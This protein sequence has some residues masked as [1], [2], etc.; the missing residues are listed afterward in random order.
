MSLQQN[1]EAAAS[2]ED[3]NLNEVIKPYLA[4]WWWFVLSVLAF[5]IL[6]IL[7]I[8]STSPSYK[9][10]ST[11]LV[12]DTKKAPS[13]D[14]GM[15][16]QL[17]GFGSMGTNS[18]DNEIEVLKSKKLMRDVV[19]ELGL[20]TKLYSKEGLKTRELY[21]KSSPVII[22]LINEKQY[23]EPIEEPLS[24]KI[25]GDKLELSS[26]EL[27]KTI[28]TTYNKTISLPYANIMIRKNVNYAPKPK[29]ELGDL[30]IHYSPT[31]ATISSFQENI[32][33]DLV[34]KDAT[35]VELSLP[36]EHIEKGKN[37]IN[38]LVDNYNSDAIQDKNSESK[39]TK[40]FIDE[41]IGIIA[42]ELGEV[43]SQKEQFKVANNIT[44]IP[45]EASLALG[46]SASIQRRL[47]E[48][49][50]QLQLTDD[51]IS[52]ASKLGSN[53]TFPSSVGLSNPTASA[54][55]NAYNQLV[56]ER[57][58]LLENA[59]PQNPVVADLNKQIAVL[60]SSVIDAL[61]KNKVAMQTSINQIEGEQNLINSKINKIPAQEKLFRSIERQQQIKENLYLMLLQ[62]R[63]EAAISLAITAPKA[64]V[65]DVAYPSDKPVSPKKMIIAAVALLLGLLF[66]FAYIYLH[67][68]FNDKIRSKHDIEKNT[69]AP[70]IGELPSLEKGDN[71]IVVQ[72]DLSPMAEAFRILITNMN[73]MLPKKAEGKVIFVSSS[74]KGEG[75][76]FTSV[77]L[78][79]TLASV[80]N[81]T[82]IIGSDIRNPQLQRY[83]PERKGLDG[84]TEFLYKEDER[85]E[86]I[87]H[88]STF[89]PHLDLIYSGSIPPNP[90]ELLANGRYEVLIS[91]LK[92]KYDYIIVDTAPLMLVTDTLLT[93]EFA[94][95]TLYVARSGITEKSL[96][97]FANTQI[98]SNKIKNVGFVLNDVSKEHFGYGNKYG[99]GYSAEK[100][101]FWQKLRDKF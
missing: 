45:A 69:K 58:N 81:K 96:I 2:S 8:K 1:S 29:D 73:F 88:V 101:S 97:D 56:L 64:R 74:V 13:S 79:L 99:Y 35:V 36:Y 66:P 10:T 37:I 23:D 60:R 43:E 30:E 47:L 53:Q 98:N 42:N 26:P 34:N 5:L 87:I 50:T 25:S 20:Q 59:T 62:R 67:E 39:K 84:L 86:D 6:A 22:Q 61:V 68:L 93:T 77:N 78:A 75:K 27:S 4:K 100:R 7:Y 15:L 54:N 32:T 76:T 65:I 28:I 85:I 12:K 82:I 70:V 38:K 9:I 3:I 14:M 33:I 11:V 48:T 83:N 55:I 90:T 17:G 52:Y 80:R 89:N 24:L 57:N 40:E 49:E 44:D 72:N 92:K 31:E 91:E 19:N 41:R 71:E 95:V 46:N 94:D 63:E 21:G 16:S 18:I 51:L